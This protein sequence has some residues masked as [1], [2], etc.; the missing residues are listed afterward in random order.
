MDLLLDLDDMGL[1]ADFSGD[2]KP[3]MAWISCDSYVCVSERVPMYLY[4]NMNRNITR[5]TSM[6]IRICARNEV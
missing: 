2:W 1:A 4:I 6:D 3:S 5:N